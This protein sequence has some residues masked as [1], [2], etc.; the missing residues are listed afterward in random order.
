MR[1]SLLLQREPFGYILEQ[2]M[3]GYWGNPSD[4]PF[5][6][7][8]WGQSETSGQLWRGNIYLNFF[9]VDDVDSACFEIIKREFSHSQKRSRRWLQ[10]AYVQ[11]AVRPPF[12]NLL[13]QVQFTVSEEVPLA[14]EQLLIGGNRRMRII[15]PAAGKSYVI[16][17]EGFSRIGF[18]REVIAREGYAAAVAPQFFGLDTGGV[19][20][21]EEYFIGTPSNRFPSEKQVSYSEEACARLVEHVHQPSL[22]TVLV[23]DYLDQL[24]ERIKEIEASLVDSIQPLF[25]WVREHAGNA[26]VGL[27]FS[28]GDFQDANILVNGESLHIIDWEN[29]TE[30]SQLYDLA[31]MSS[32][33]RLSADS[34][35]S[36]CDQVEQWVAHA[37]DFP[38]LEVPA[39]GSNEMLVCAV[40]WWIEEMIFQLEEAQASSFAKIDSVIERE[41]LRLD[42]VHKRVGDLSS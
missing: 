12:R 25:N 41:K 10:A 30:R 7:V 27:V 22:R 28:H 40:I 31:T 24:A 6:T 21:A 13:S 17:K 42:V 33:V 1:L 4:S 39:Q 19:S 23:A 29:A 37:D 9:C 8:R 16:Q 3:A 15:H 11:A 18:D 34:A 36:W 35:Q 14:C 5:K 32:G 38:R 20:F 2:T 26:S